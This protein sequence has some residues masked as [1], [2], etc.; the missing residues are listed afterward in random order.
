MPVNTIRLRNG[1]TRK[2]NNCKWVSGKQSADLA[3]VPFHIRGNPTLPP[4]LFS[5]IWPRS[6]ILADLRDSPLFPPSRKQGGK[7][8]ISP[9][10]LISGGIPRWLSLHPRFQPQGERQLIPLICKINAN[11]ELSDILLHPFRIGLYFFKIKKS[12]EHSKNWLDRI[13]V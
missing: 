10:L 12:S 4:P 13:A 3:L 9:D 1:R 2:V 6:F 11:N 7:I 8:R 5:T